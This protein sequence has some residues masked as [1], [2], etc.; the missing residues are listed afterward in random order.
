MN[1]FKVGDIVEHISSGEIYRVINV[2][3][4]V[5]G[6]QTIRIYNK[7]FNYEEDAIDNSKYFKYPDID[8]LK[9]YKAIILLTV[10]CLDGEVRMRIF[11]MAEKYRCKGSLYSGKCI[12]CSD[13]YPNIS[14]HSHPI[15]Y[16]RGSKRQDDNRIVIYN[17]STADDYNDIKNT[18]EEW[19]AYVIGEAEA[20]PN[21][22]VVENDK[23]LFKDVVGYD[24]PKFPW[25]L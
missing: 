4:I 19:G 8:K 12:I 9:I 17:N 3:H 21:N 2:G 13:A 1:N 11:D 6:E 16:L 7:C 18:L 15:I 10:D 25:N 14:R 22:V 5:N 24:S 20:V 23:Y